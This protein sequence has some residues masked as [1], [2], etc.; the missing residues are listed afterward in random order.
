MNIKIITTSVF[1]SFFI[2]AAVIAQDMTVGTVVLGEYSTRFHYRGADIIRNRAY[3]I[4]KAIETLD[5]TILRPDETLSYN[6]LL[7]QRT[8][9]RGWRQAKT[10]QDGEI[11]IDFGGGICQV[12]STLHAAALYSGMD[13]VEAQ[14]HSRYMTYIEPGLDA[15]VNWRQPDLLIRNR[16]TFPIRIHAWE[17]EPGTVVIQ[18][19][20]ER[21]IWEVTVERTILSQR[22][23]RTEIRQRDD[24][25][26]THRQ[27]LERGTNFLIFDQRV[28]MRNLETEELYSYT[29]RYHYDSSPRIIEV[30]TIPLATD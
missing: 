9:R 14:H 26:T 13:I 20:G 25:P 11:F 22:R 3:N 27:I 12:S 5:G 29:T 24:L 2:S 1:I 18:I 19:L 17:S 15:T 16:Y 30:G 4:R 10:I 8:G 28:D 7:G 23:Y 21:R 6:R